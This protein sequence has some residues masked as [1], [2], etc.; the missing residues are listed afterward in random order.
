MVLFGMSLIVDPLS[1]LGSDVGGKTATMTVLSSNGSLDLGYWAEAF[2]PDGSLYPF[3]STSVMDGKWVNATTFPMLYLAWPLHE[4]GGMHLAMILPVLGGVFTATAARRLAAMLGP[5]DGTVAFWIVG[6]GTPV[7]VYSLAFWEH[8]PGL[9]LMSWGLVA[10]VTAVDNHRLAPALAA[11]LL[12]GLAATMRQEAL[13]YGAL[14]GIGLV[15]GLATT[16]RPLVMLRSSIAMATG[17]LAMLM[18]N[19]VFERL[20]LGSVLRSSRRRHGQPRRD[21]AGRSTP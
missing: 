7:T 3:Y 19:T 14:A 8:A 15:I 21:Q 18:A 6:L 11:G 17:G 2:D 9:A 13:V 1:S 20:V 4:L 16:A 12:F 10:V 5:T